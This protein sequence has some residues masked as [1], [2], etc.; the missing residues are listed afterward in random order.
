MILVLRGSSGA[1]KTFVGKSLVER[2]AVK[3]IMW[4][5]NTWP[6][7]NKH[8]AKLVGYELKGDLFVVGPYHTACGGGDMI[9]GGPPKVQI[10]FAARAAARYSHVFLESLMASG[11]AAHHYAKLRDDTGQEVVLPTLDTPLDECIANVYKR[12]GG[13]SKGR[14]GVPLNTD[15]MA[16][17][18]RRIL[19]GGRDNLL[20]LGLEAP[21]IDYHRATE[22]VEELL[23]RGGWN[24]E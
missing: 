20:A 15:A 5:A 6:N 7:R 13:G 16:G 8:K 21:I 24:P 12:N 23:R 18:H 1:G 2:Y 11:S 22:L 17:S 9:Y 14:V 3:E 19:G 10:P 4:P